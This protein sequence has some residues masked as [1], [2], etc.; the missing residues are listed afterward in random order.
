MFCRVNGRRGGTQ[1][2]SGGVILVFQGIERDGEGHKLNVKPNGRKENQ[3]IVLPKP[4]PSPIAEAIGSPPSP[5]V[6]ARE[7]KEKSGFYVV[8]ERLRWRMALLPYTLIEPRGA[9]SPLLVDSPH[10]GRIYPVDF[11]YACPLPLLRQVEDAFVDEL[12]AGAAEAGA[13]VIMAEF[14]RSLIDVNRAIDDIDPAVLDGGWPNARP[15][16]NTLQG[17]GLVRRL[18]RAGV[19]IYRTPVTAADIRTRIDRFYRPYHDALKTHVQQRLNQFG[20]CYLLDMH[21]MPSHADINADIILGNRDGASCAP[22][23]INTAQQIFEAMGYRVAR[24]APYKGREIVRRYGREGMGA[25]A[26]QIEISRKLYMDEATLAKHAGFER[27]RCSLNAFFA[28]FSA[29]AC[30]SVEALAAE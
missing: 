29:K 27:I 30:Q 21:S 1:A 19:D 28:D 18:C 22:Q 10:S 15:E 8:N 17:Y 14:P 24:N 4:S 26:L 6:R 20:V 16:P 7:T 23:V 3:I 9:P 2:A 5:A 12:V 13:T 25:Q 11:A